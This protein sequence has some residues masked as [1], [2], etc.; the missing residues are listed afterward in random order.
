LTE[1]DELVFSQ[2]EITAF[3]SQ[4]QEELGIEAAVVSTC[5][6]TEFYLFGPAEKVGWNRIREQLLTFKQLNAEQVPAPDDKRAKAAANH[7]F[8]VS[9]SLESVALGENE[10][11]GQLKDAHE[12][13]VEHPIASSVLDELFQYAIRAGKDVRTETDLCEGAVSVSSVAVELAEKIFGDLDV[14]DILIVGAGEMAEKAAAHFKDRGAEQF[15][16]A[17]RSTETG[18]QL[19]GALGGAYVPLEDVSSSLAASDIVL[20]ATGA[21]EYL[22]DESDIERARRDGA[23]SPMFLIDISNPRNVDPAVSDSDAVYL[24]NMNDLESVVESNLSARQKEIPKAEEIIADYVVQWERWMSSREVQPTIATLAQYFED[25]REQELG[26]MEGRLPEDQLELLENFSQ[27]LV[28]KLLHYPITY[29]RSAE[30]DNQL[31]AGDLNLVWSLYNLH[32]YR[33]NNNEN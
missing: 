15:T 11:L 14:C 18:E 8:R 1:R 32:E 9:A 24:Y 19:A 31:N 29:L 25:V 33:D 16:I 5:N 23:A 26:R 21:E 10:I 17:N 2:D 22:I 27:G 4:I 13:F 12:L 7:L 3:Y 6:R 30:E 20:T 28:N